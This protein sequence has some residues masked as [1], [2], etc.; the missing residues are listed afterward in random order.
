MRAGEHTDNVVGGLPLGLPV[1]TQDGSTVDLEHV[2]STAEEDTDVLPPPSALGHA[3][4][5][6]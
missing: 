1:N 3:W 5:V 2:S 4:R 6:S